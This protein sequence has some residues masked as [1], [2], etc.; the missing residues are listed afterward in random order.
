MPKNPTPGKFIVLEGI[1]GHAIE[2]QGKRLHGWLREQ[3]VMAHLT[4]EPSDGPFGSQIRFILAGRLKMDSMTLVPLFATDRMDHL[5]KED[6]ILARLDAG[7]HV[8]CLRYYLSSLAYQ[9]IYADLEWIRAI[10]A[11]CRRPDLTVFIDTLVS[12]RLEH[13]AESELCTDD[14]LERERERLEQVRENYQIA[15]EALRQEG[16]NIVV[17]AGNRLARSITDTIV[18]LMKQDIVT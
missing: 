10:N 9:S 8:I 16:E 2:E 15:I 13:L 14:E 18:E 5:N 6:G 3:K 7:E 1:D 11:Q 17:I 12:A 4:R